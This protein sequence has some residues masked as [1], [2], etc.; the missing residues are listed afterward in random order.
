MVKAR[1]RGMVR[2]GG[3]RCTYF[4][5]VLVQLLYS[6]CMVKGLGVWS[7]VGS[8]VHTCVLPASSVATMNQPLT[9]STQL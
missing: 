4:L 9:G 3:G 8:D 5:P 2:G 7:G 6:Y 1:V